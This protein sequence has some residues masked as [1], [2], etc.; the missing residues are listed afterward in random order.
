MRK[1]MTFATAALQGLGVAL[2]AKAV[3]L[4]AAPVP[5]ALGARKWVPSALWHARSVP[6][7]TGATPPALR[8]SMIASA[9]LLAA[10]AVRKG[11]QVPVLV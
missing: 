11:P 4:P 8:R 3:T 10:G 2:E 5:W 1:A 9:A 6:R 7:A